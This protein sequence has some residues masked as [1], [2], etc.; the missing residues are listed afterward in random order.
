VCV[1]ALQLR[2]AGAAAVAAQP[3][4]PAPRRCARRRAVHTLQRTTHVCVCKSSVSVHRCK[5]QTGLSR[6]QAD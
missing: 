1:L 3:A 2:H 5:L 4:A 6:F